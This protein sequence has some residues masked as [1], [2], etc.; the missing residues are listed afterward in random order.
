MQIKELKRQLEINPQI[1][2][3]VI[4]HTAS[5]LYLV[6]IHNAGEI[7][8]LTGWRGQ[9]RVFRSLEEVTGELKHHGIKRA[10]LL[11]HVANDEVIGRESFYQG[12]NPAALNLC[13]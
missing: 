4:N 5:S 6:E 9:Q 2:V 13:Y 7:E 3:C 10:V 11:N 8:L 12:L 1:Q